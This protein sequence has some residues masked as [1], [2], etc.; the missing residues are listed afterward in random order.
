MGKGRQEEDRRGRQWSGVFHH[1]SGELEMDELYS[2]G[3]AFMGVGLE[4]L[5]VLLL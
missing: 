1:A 5:V 3:F 4:G 2:K